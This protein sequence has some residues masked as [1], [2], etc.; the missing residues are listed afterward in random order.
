ML[1]DI[2]LEVSRLCSKISN[3]DLPLKDCDDVD[4][5][6]VEAGGQEESEFIYP[7][8][9]MINRGSKNQPKKL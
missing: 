5:K 7:I 9:D 2:F 6:Y 1:C 4:Y 3:C 8:E